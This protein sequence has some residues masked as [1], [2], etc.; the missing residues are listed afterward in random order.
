M[1]QTLLNILAQY[2]RPQLLLILRVQLL[3]PN[4]PF[5]LLTP[6]GQSDDPT[7]HPHM[8]FLRWCRRRHR[9]LGSS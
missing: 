3:E 7:I 8:S 2:L 6:S 4:H 5:L 9:G 1:L